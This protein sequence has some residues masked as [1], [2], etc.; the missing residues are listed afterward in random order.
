M[1]KYFTST[2]CSVSETRVAAGQNVEDHWFQQSKNAI[3][4]LIELSKTLKVEEMEGSADDAWTSFS[5]KTAGAY[6]EKLSC[7][8]AIDVEEISSEAAILIEAAK[9]ESMASEG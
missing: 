5:A 8:A 6:F 3:N 9:R 1:S 2:I 4:C 7:G